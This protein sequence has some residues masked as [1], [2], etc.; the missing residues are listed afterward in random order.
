M[1]PE[2]HAQQQFLDVVGRD[3]AERRF[4]AA[5]DL[6]PLETEA[7]PLAKA[8]GPSAGRRRDRAARRAELD[9]SNV[10]GFACVRPYLRAS[11]DKPVPL[12]LSAEILSTGMA[13]RETVKA[14]WATAIATGAMLPR[15]ADAVIMI[16]HTDVGRPGDKET[17]RQGDQ[18]HQAGGSP[19]LPVSMSSCLLLFRPVAPGANITFAGTD[20]GQ[21]ETVLRRGEQMTSR[22]TGVLRRSASRKSA[23]CASRA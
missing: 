19:C 8:L 3:E 13:P 14:G 23:S 4:T 11:E 10:D 17:R 21:G 1:T 12:R 20:I 22:E 5:L 16:E 7:V 18:D 15:G 9:R 2:I 6:R